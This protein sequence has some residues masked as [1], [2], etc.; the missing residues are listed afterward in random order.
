M[1]KPTVLV[2]QYEQ[3]LASSPDGIALMAAESDGVAVYAVATGEEVLRKRFKQN[4]F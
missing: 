2:G 3:M 4:V 1:Q